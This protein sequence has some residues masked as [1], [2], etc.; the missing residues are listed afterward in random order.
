MWVRYSDHTCYHCRVAACWHKSAT[1]PARLPSSP[2]G[3]ECGPARQLCAAADV[4]YY[5][6]RSGRMNDALHFLQTKSRMHGHA[7]DSDSAAQS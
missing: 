4:G 2:T 5:R 3:L 1:Q 6:Q 7:C